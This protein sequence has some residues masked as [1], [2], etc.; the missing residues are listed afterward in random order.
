MKNID[1]N[2]NELFVKSLNQTIAT[3][4]EKENK[5]ISIAKELLNN[6]IS[7]AIIKIIHTPY[8]VLKIYLIVF[9]I[10]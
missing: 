5:V 2:M 8:V 7:Q 3:K 9:I 6:S 4:E 1:L 10:I